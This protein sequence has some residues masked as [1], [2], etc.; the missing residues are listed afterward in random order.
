MNNK[1]RIR[2]KI[3]KNYKKILSSG[4]SIWSNHLAAWGV[5]FFSSFIDAA[6]LYDLAV[7]TTNLKVIT[8]IIIVVG[9]AFTID[10]IPETIGEWVA[11]KIDGE[12][13]P[14]LEIIV[15]SVV[16]SIGFSS[17]AWLRWV[18]RNLLVSRN[19]IFTNFMNE[20]QNYIETES[21]PIEA[22][23]IALVL[24]SIM[25]ATSYMTFWVGLQQ[26][27]KQVR[28]ERSKKM[29]NLEMKLFEA[30]IKEEIER[31]IPPEKIR[32]L[33]LNEDK[34]RLLSARVKLSAVSKLFKIKSREL[35][36]R[37]KHLNADD[38]T[39]LADEMDN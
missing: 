4:D 30:S 14:I 28:A 13:P 12:N 9:G 23:A 25:L 38:V 18:N 2:K 6:N 36:L 32:D 8:C 3:L 21:V 11:K 26:P 39:Y 34:E 19:G 17:V 15:E 22:S 7:T 33:L 16:F 35:L 37:K 24:I 5:I 31:Q 27:S 10:L 20:T 29:C 1:K